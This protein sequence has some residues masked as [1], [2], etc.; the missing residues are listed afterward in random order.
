MR[1][2]VLLLVAGVLVSCGSCN[3]TPESEREWGFRDP[4]I[5]R[6]I[7]VQIRVIPA[8][9]EVTAVSEQ[10]VVTLRGRVTS[11]EA[12]EQAKEIA[13]DVSDVQD[14]KSQIEIRKK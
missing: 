5:E 7:S 3:T 11:R 8:L 6:E 12:E 13:W 9:K 14:V 1:I 4:E 2:C 10:G